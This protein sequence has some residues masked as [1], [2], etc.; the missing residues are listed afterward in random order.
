MIRNGWLRLEE[1]RVWIPSSRIE[2]I[3]FL[4]DVGARISLSGG[5]IVFTSPEESD[6][7]L[8]S[9]ASAWEPQND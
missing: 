1:G 5:E 6:Y 9:L 2:R 4:Q 3:T 8:I 7:L